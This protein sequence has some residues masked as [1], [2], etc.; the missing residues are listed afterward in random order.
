MNV[1]SLDDCVLFGTTLKASSWVLLPAEPV[2]SRGSNEETGGVLPSRRTI[3]E[4]SHAGRKVS[5]RVVHDFC[6]KCSTV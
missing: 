1:P 5:V 6:N 3:L 2:L 4:G